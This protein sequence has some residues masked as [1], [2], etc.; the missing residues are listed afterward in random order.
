MAWLFHE[1]SSI[2]GLDI[3]FETLKLVQLEQQAKRI[4]LHG[5]INLPLSER[6]LDK[7]RFRDKTQTAKMIQQ[8]CA[9]AKPRPIEAK[10]IVSVLPETFVFSKTIQMPKMRE[11]E[12][13][14]ALPLEAAQYL[15]L[16]IEEVYLDY[17]ILIVHPDEPLID[18]LFVAS[19]RR[20][21][22]DYVETARM[23]GM[24][25]MALETKP[26]ALGRAL[27][28][29]KDNAGYLIAAVGTEITRISIWDG[30]KI[31]LTTTVGMGQNQLDDNR[32]LSPIIEEMIE[33]IR[34]HQNRDYRPKPI[35]QI[36]ICGSGAKAAGLEEIIEE[37]LKID[38][39][40]AKPDL[41]GK[42]TLGP[43]FVTAYGL[44]LRKDEE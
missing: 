11:A 39:I 41:V 34:Y 29:A 36:L 18:L 42:N 9:N 12:Y 31:R 17:Q 24:E 23:A 2:F 15:P 44:A 30:N 25:L 3:G 26:L 40:I 38:T 5:A 13:A 6:I 37:K 20:L 27:L 32:S 19:P 8:A 28:S 10:K 4:F 7:D 35:K 1:T 16:P 21:V 43:E 22:D 14:R 33:A